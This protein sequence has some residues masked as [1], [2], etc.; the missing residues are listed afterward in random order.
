MQ[1]HK[2]DCTPTISKTPKTENQKKRFLNP[3]SRKYD[4][5]RHIGN[6]LNAILT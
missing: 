2:S 4:E 6:D 1:H 3:H 5:E